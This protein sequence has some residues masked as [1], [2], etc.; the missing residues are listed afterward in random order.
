MV[1]NGDM[2]LTKDDFKGIR[3]VVREEIETE[4]GNRT[5]EIKSEAK[6]NMIRLAGR[7]DGVESRVKNSEIAIKRELGK[8]QKDLKFAIK[9]LDKQDIRT[10]ERITK[11]EENLNF[12][13]N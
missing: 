5:E 8:V 12:P 2:T 3:E 9:F 13:Q 1:L 7:I 4:V 6:M 11:I 10:E